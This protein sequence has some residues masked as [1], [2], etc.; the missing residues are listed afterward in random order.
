MSPPREYPEYSPPGYYAVFFKD[1]E[2]IKCE[3]VHADHNE[4]KA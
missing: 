3:I 1:P 2:G 4:A